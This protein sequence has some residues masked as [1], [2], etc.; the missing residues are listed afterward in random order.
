M[1]SS[2]ALLSPG[3]EA[4]M[5]SVCT[6]N[7][8]TFSESASGVVEGPERSSPIGL[9]EAKIRAMKERTTLRAR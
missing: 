8:V 4:V 1:F 7:A 5:F 6:G 2:G 3:A 9:S